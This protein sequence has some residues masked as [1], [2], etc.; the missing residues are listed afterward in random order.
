MKRQVLRQNHMFISFAQ[1]G[2]DKILEK[3][4]GE[5]TN[6]GFF[7]DVGANHPHKFSNTF[8]LYLKGWRG[9]NIDA[10]PG[11]KKLFDEFRPGDINIETGISK[12]PGQLEYHIFEHSLFN[13]FDKETAMAHVKEFDVKITEV[14]TLETKPLAAVLDALNM[15]LPKIDFLTVDVEGLDLEI[16]ESN[17]WKKYKPEVILIEVLHSDLENIKDKAVYQYL[18][19]LGYKLFAKTYNTLFFT[20]RQRN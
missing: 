7:I 16:L 15:E 4:F 18:H 13:T 10:N 14:V 5:H 12:V 17:N 8:K 1:E 9:I 6:T 19:N 20:N 2:E 3:Y 11:T